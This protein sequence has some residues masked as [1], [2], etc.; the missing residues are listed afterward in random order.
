M[1]MSPRRNPRAPQFVLV[2]RQIWRP[3]IRRISHDD[4]HTAASGGAWLRAPRRPGVA[5]AVLIW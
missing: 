4:R 5:E 1:L 3:V 2:G